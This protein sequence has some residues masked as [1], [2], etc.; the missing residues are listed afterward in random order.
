MRISKNETTNKKSDAVLI[1][2]VDDQ[3][4]RFLSAKN[5]DLIEKVRQ[6]CEQNNGDPATVELTN[7]LTL[8]PRIRWK[9]LSLVASQGKNVRI[10]VAEN[11]KEYTCLLDA[12]LSV[13]R[14]KLSLDRQARAQAIAVEV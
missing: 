3:A 4:Y 7:L 8:D 2:T 5:K 11:G 1:V 14:S 9:V 13:V 12:V 10:S 6:E